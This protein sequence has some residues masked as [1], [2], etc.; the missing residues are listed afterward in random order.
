M[1]CNASILNLCF[2]AL[3]V[4]LPAQVQERPSKPAAP[5]EDLPTAVESPDV[6][7]FRH[8]VAAQA[9]EQQKA[10]FQVVGGTMDAARRQASRVKQAA[11]T[12]AGAEELS[13][14]TTA[15][16]DAIYDAQHEN[17]LLLKS[18]SDT[19]EAELKKLTAKL[20]KANAA[21]GKLSDA[22]QDEMSR[23]WPDAKRV[24]AE[25]AALDKELAAMQS[26]QRNLAEEMGIKRPRPD[27]DAGHPDNR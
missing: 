22:I 8:M 11:T 12:G 18:L 5:P 25:V 3:V 10:Q 2:L 20:R 27:D 26:D 7:A 16:R 21:V 6:I 19:Q 15:L 4:V 13:R 17:F 14:S 23:R 1:R 9:N 24:G